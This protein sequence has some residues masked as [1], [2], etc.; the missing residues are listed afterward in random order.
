MLGPMR[1]NKTVK[2]WFLYITIYNVEKRQF[3]K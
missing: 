2:A 1:F 3:T